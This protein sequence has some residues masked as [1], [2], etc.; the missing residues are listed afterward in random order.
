MLLGGLLAAAV[1]APATGAATL[2]PSFAEAVVAGG[3]TSPTALAIA[4]DGRIFVTQQGNCAN[5]TCPAQVRVVK[6]GS[7]LPTAFATLTVNAPP[8]SERGLLGIALDPGFPGTPYVYVYYTAPTPAI[9]NRLSRIPASGDVAGGPEEPL[10]DLESL[11]A[12]N[13]NGGAIHFSPSDGKLYVAVGENAVSSNSQSCDNRLGKILR[14]NAEGSI[15]GDNPTF[16]AFCPPGTT[17]VNRAIWALGLRNPF[18][19]AFQQGT[20]RMFV[21]DV[22]S[23]G[24]DPREEINDGIAGSNYGWPIVEGVASNPAFRD[25]LFD[26]G[27]TPSPGPTT[28][29][30]I[31][32][33][34]FYNPT[35]QTFPADYLG[36]YFFGDLC[37]GWIRRYDVASDTAGDFISGTSSPVDLAVSDDGSLYYLQRGG[38]GQLYRVTYGAPTVVAAH[39]FTAARIARGVLL[40]WRSGDPR[41]LGFDVYRDGRR[42]SRS[43]VRGSSFVDV[44]A[45][46]GRALRYRLQAV[47]G[48]GSRTWVAWVRLAG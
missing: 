1:G 20:G 36:D 11:A 28:G 13:H 7:L 34:A 21:N 29:C 33:A 45:P 18:T 6:N 24:A 10:L 39:S 26:Y 47:L 22:G 25:P 42:L 8:G 37:S 2:P 43:V 40:R 15:P 17:G 9:H 32:G 41:V 30:A 46:R 5:A 3:L 23:S 19:F 44:A 35:T 14:L 48:D 4:P 38:G 16:A 12:T 31:V 27:H